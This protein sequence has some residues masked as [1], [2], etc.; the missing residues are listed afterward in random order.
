MIRSLVD[1]IDA[2]ADASCWV[3]DR[4]PWSLAKYVLWR[5]G[6]SMYELATDVGV[7]GGYL[8]RNPRYVDGG[9]EPMFV[10]R[11]DA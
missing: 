5:F 7:R 4:M 11:E 1:A 2:V 3:A 8:I 10:R 9:D 6:S